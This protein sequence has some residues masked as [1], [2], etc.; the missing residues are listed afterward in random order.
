MRE[1]VPY[2]NIFLLLL[3][4]LIFAAA[5]RA[6]RLSLK[7]YTS[8]DGLAH[9]T[10]NRIVP[11]SRGFLWF[12]TEDGLSRF[13]GFRFKNYTQEQGLP[14]RNINDF[15]ETSDGTYLVATSNGLAVFNA[16][17]K[18][19]RWNVVE[20]RI[21]RSSAEAPLFTT[22]FP[23][24]EASAS[25]S[26]SIR[27]LASDSAGNI[28]AVMLHGV[29]RVVRAGEEW[30][31]EKI[32]NAEWEARKTEFSAL[33]ED[34][35]GA[36]WTAT[37]TGV[38]R[39]LKN[40]AIEKVSE[41]GANSLFR[42]RDGRIW[43][44]SGGYEVGI[45]I[46]AAPHGDREAVLEKTYTVRDGLADNKFSNAVAETPDGQIFA[47]S[48]NRLYRLRGD[49]E[50]GRLAFEPLG[51]ESV[52]AIAQ[53]QNQSV[54]LGFLNKGAARFTTNDF[55]NLTSADG[56]SE[57][58]GA[59]LT[60]RRG[61]LVYVFDN[62]LFRLKDGK[63][64]AIKPR[65]MPARSWG[66]RYLDFQSATGDWWIPTVGGLLRYDTIGKAED[67]A[68]RA[69]S[70]IYT[71]A[72][73]LDSPT[74][75]SA[76]EDSRGDVW[77][78]TL[79]RG[80]LHRLEKST[81]RIESFAAE[82]A[83]PKDS[84]AVSYGE[85]AAGGV[86][87]GFFHGD[88]V[89]FRNGTFR[90]LTNE[91]VLPRGKVEQF[92]RDSKNRLWLATSNRGVF[93]VDETNAETPVFKN[94]STADGLPSNQALSL[95][96]D[97]FGRIFIGTGRGI[98]RLDPETGKIKIYTTADGLANNAA[99]YS[100]KDRAGN[101]WF[102]SYNTLTRFAP[103]SD[104]P[105]P[106]PPVFIDAVSAGGKARTVSELGAAALQHL[107]FA[108]DERQIQIGFFAVSFESGEMLRYQYRLNDQNWSA[109]VDQRSV[110]FD[111]A[112]GSYEFAVRAINA[113]GVASEK[114]ATFS[115][116][117]LRP[118]WQRWWFL[119]SAAIAVSL[120][121]FVVYRRRM[122]NLRRINEALSEAKK[123]EER[124]RKTREERLA[125]LQRVR[126]RIATDLHD[127]IGSSLTQIAV[128]SEV[129]RKSVSEKKEL[130]VAPLESISAVSNEL[131][132][133]MADIVWAIN[134]R[135]DSLRELVFRMRRFASDV[136]AARDIEFE[137]DAPDAE[138][139]IQLGAN[140]RRELFAIFK[141]C[142]NNIVRHSGAKNVD[143]AFGIDAREIVVRI[144]DDGH[145]FDAERVLSEDFSPDKGGNGL[146]NMR[147]RARD[148]GG[149]CEISSGENGTITELKIPLVA[150]FETNG[151]T[152]HT[153]SGAADH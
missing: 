81:G 95:V 103:Q 59:L 101:L 40:G 51:V 145:G 120:V 136:L 88:V 144:A 139:Q 3:G 84:L 33:L 149:S 32:R 92:L 121:I 128:L 151:A 99:V 87:F 4:S 36:L 77:F 55:V 82:S 143:I 1:K 153:G 147:R 60:D 137:L 38:Y 23:S 80:V 75:F 34:A 105:S 58:L 71:V 65:A 89:R 113:D 131:V 102:A 45:R 57:R 90:S 25:P 110:S 63:I 73:G 108:P 5:A 49:A 11:D 93:R 94:I 41:T 28:Y 13:D 2:K 29:Y 74:V 14:H 140:I 19:F 152:N 135:K 114:S 22:F 54:W 83:L 146:I 133:A 125:E 69:P 129:A 62:R 126:T 112:A 134:P 67:L 42:T 123:A 68:R 106:P 85:D 17:G 86:W 130:P 116:T 30:R 122:E 150:P 37:N 56:V 142:V 104:K 107:E 148:L 64:E 9:D 16:E 47:T 21:E 66:W 39:I 115:F 124:L 70:R 132:E 138:V 35:S 12:C 53:Y 79:E 117:V 26:K 43:V 48:V 127:D 61:D 18:A 52:T 141:E 50:G 31:F 44:D 27:R 96:E 7:T 24:A 20:E 118:V 98:V 91:N 119:I 109:P 78:G 10:V 72:D 76:F 15:L 8:A 97:G 6:E 100:L 46:Y 111:L